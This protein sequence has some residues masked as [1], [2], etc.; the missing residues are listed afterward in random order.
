MYGWKKNGY[1]VNIGFAFVTPQHF[2]HLDRVILVMIDATGV[3]E[4]IPYTKSFLL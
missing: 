4:F 1:Y 2:C 3:L